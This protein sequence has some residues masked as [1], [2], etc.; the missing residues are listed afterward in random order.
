MSNLNDLDLPAVDEGDEQIPDFDTLPAQIGDFADP[1]QP[2]PYIF[3]MPKSG[4]KFTPIVDKDNKPRLKAEFHDHLQLRIEGMMDRF[5]FTCDSI[6]YPKGEGKP[7]VSKMTYLLAALK[8]VPNS[9]SRKDM[10]EALDRAC[11]REGKF[12]G[13]TSLSGWCNAEKDIYTE[14]GKKAGTKGCGRRFS[15]NPYAPDATKIAANKALQ[16]DPYHGER[17]AIPVDPSDPTKYSLKFKCK[18]GAVLRAYSNI[19]VF[20]VAP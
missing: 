15:S 9:G 13:T 5:R 14:E 12:L 18:C 19:D 7:K 6:P 2:G 1:I 8:E 4:P 3:V 11:A 20:R 10:G 17:F 16:Q